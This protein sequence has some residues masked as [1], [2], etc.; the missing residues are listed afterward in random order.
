MNGQ[1]VGRDVSIDINT[2]RG[3][4]ALSA[5]AITNF[6]SQPKTSNVE[7]KGMDAVTRH[8]VFPE[9][10]RG[11]F[12]VDRMSGVLDTFWAQIE[13]DYYAGVNTLPGTI[14]ETIAEPDGSISQYRYTG[15]MF[16][17]KDAGAKAANGLVK[18]KLDFMAS[19]RLK[20]A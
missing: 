17:F 9:G 3:I 1:T 2:S 16:D 19:R 14:T 6:T 10:W 13:A 8:G 18:Q 4:L 20:V 11:T 12:D 7:S 15:V 5:T